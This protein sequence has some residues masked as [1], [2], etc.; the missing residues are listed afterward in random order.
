MKKRLLQALLLSVIIALLNAHSLAPI[1]GQGEIIKTD[2][3]AQTET[4]NYKRNDKLLIN[5]KE[6][7][8]FYKPIQYKSNLL[9]RL[10]MADKKSRRERQELEKLTS[11]M[12]FELKLIEPIENK[13]EYFIAYKSIIARYPQITQGHETIYDAFT[14]EELSLLFKVVQAEIGDY[15][16]EQK[17]NV[18]SVIFNRMTH[19]RF[20]NTLTEIL[21]YDQFESISN[22]MYEKVQIDETTILACEYVY[23]FGVTNNCVFF[24]SNGN[25]SHYQ[26]VFNDGAHNFYKIK[27]E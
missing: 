10:I 27:G 4:T 17:C 23:I 25:L 1:E 16:F 19:D 7:G 5:K 3:A 13:E 20:P 18:V 11:S 12:A 21:S 22:G 26:Y 6:S 9:F 14:E 8:M 2:V 15:S 24:D